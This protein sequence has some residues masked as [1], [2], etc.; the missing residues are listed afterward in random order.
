MKQLEEYRIKADNIMKDLDDDQRLKR[1]QLL[2]AETKCLREVED[3]YN[4]EYASW[5]NRLRFRKQVFINLKK[6]SF[7]YFKLI[8]Y[9][10]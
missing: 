6:I 8:K 1:K 5:Q 2:D 9:F 10:R 7:N 3:K 4:A